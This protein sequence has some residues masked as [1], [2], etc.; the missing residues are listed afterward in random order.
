MFNGHSVLSILRRLSITHFE[1]LS[2]EVLYEIFDYL[3]SCHIYEAFSN[4]NTRFQYLLDYSPVPLRIN[5]TLRSKMI[6]EHRCKYIVASNLQRI[7]L[8]RLSGPLAIDLFLRSFSIDSRFT[9]LESLIFNNIKSDKLLPQL[10]QLQS[11]PRLVSLSFTTNNNLENESDVYQAIF[12]LPMLKYIKLSFNYGSPPL[13]MAIADTE[14]E[15][16]STIE[17]LTIDGPCRLDILNA[18]LSYL[19]RLRRL[20]CR[21]LSFNNNTQTKVIMTSANLT[22]LSI[23]YCSLPF[24]KFASFVSNISRHLQVLRIGTRDNND[25]MNADGWE[26]LISQHMPH[27]RIFDF[28]HRSVTYRNLETYHAIIDRFTSPFWRERQ[29]YFAHQHDSVSHLR[30]VAFYSTQPYRYR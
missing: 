22:N 11:V 27:L 18:L 4:L 29:W 28:L 10:I 30:E 20:S 6:F 2:N 1:A 5:L 3:D 21:L 7:V 25:Y 23:E 8:L 9:R 13:Q 14:Q 15:Q 24:D 19:P 12:R 16:S 17:S 26:Q